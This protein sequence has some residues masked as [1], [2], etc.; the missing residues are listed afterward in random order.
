MSRIPARLMPAY[1]EDMWVV[2]GN[3]DSRLPKKIATTSH[4]KPRRLSRNTVTPCTIRFS[5][6]ATGTESVPTEEKAV[7]KRTHTRLAT[8]SLRNKA[9]KRKRM[10]R[11]A[12][13]TKSAKTELFDISAMIERAPRNCQSGPE[14]GRSEACSSQ[15]ETNHESP[16]RTA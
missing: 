3:L 8:Q 6:R 10:S 14:R 5:T 12:S 2:R 15:E 11:I 16:L 13:D 4:S 7:R 1:Q 9:R